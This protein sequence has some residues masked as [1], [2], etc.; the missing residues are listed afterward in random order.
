MVYA[1]LCVVRG[2]LLDEGGPGVR[3]SGRDWLGT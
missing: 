2:F 3:L 1:A